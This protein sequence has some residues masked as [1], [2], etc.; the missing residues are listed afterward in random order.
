V[1]FG[2]TSALGVT[3]GGFVPEPGS[4]ATMLGGV[5]LSLLR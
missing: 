2:S 4:M 1:I 5:S 3:S